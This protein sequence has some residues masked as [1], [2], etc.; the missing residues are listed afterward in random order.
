MKDGGYMERIAGEVIARFGAFAA[1]IARDL[2][3][4]A[5]AVPDEHSAETWCD[6]ADAIERISMKP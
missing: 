3:T 1:L 4:R 2:A 6:I 5:A